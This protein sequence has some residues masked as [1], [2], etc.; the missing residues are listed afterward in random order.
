MNNSIKISTYVDFGS[1]INVIWKHIT[2]DEKGGT[3]DVAAVDTYLNYYFQ[4]IRKAGQSQIFLSFAQLCNLENYATKNYDSVTCP[5]PPVQDPIGCTL[6]NTKGIAI[7]GFSSTQDL[8][9]YFIDRA[10]TNGLPVI[11]AFGGLSADDLCFKVLQEPTDTYSDKASQLVTAITNYGFS[12]VDFDIEDA[13]ALIQ[14]NDST[15]ATIFDFFQ[16][17][18]AQL[19]Q[20]SLTSSISL[21][22]ELSANWRSTFKDLF[23]DV[24]SI[25]LMAYS[26]TQYYL[27]PTPCGK[28]LGYSIQE[29]LEASNLPAAAFRIGFDDGI[30][31]ENASANGGACSHNISTGSTSGQA[32]AQIFTELLQNQ[33]ELQ[34]FWWPAWDTARY[35]PDPTTGVPTNIVSQTMIDF[36][37]A[38]TSQTQS[39]SIHKK[40]SS[41]AFLKWILFILRNFFKQK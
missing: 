6:K 11:L 1:T 8:L 34:A 2:W 38:L 41:G 32:A 16:E 33:P 15:Q 31:Y 22:T 5:P 14:P 30:P 28:T 20:K 35:Q 3:L 24:N 29:W 13:N 17:V 18:K 40:P 7:A 36:Y 9:D 27:D 26:D 10:K 23:P 19:T 39:H 37:T 12:G 25:N 4:Q 21:T